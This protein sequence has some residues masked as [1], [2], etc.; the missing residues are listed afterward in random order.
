MK[1]S[2]PA[3]RKA[4]LYTSGNHNHHKYL[5]L[6]SPICSA[7]KAGLVPLVSTPRLLTLHRKY[8]FSSLA[9][10]NPQHV[11]ANAINAALN[12]VFLLLVEA[13]H[14]LA[15]QLV[16]RHSLRHHHYS[17]P[18][19]RRLNLPQHRHC[20]ETI[21]SKRKSPNHNKEEA[22]LEPRT[23]RN[24]MGAACLGTQRILR[25]ALAGP[26]SVPSSHLIIFSATHSNHNLKLAVGSL[27]LHL[28]RRRT[29]SQATLYSVLRATRASSRC[30]E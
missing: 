9:N 21:K 28:V 15:P 17:E 23:R 20:L 1:K 27:G 24:L 7:H 14:C 22:Y 12:Q 29:S 5:V 18:L 4:A 26:C 11:L 30:C 2:R 6:L 16:L 13:S 25:R 3:S 10:L 19:Q 8:S